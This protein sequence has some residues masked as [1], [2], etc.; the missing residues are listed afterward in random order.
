LKFTYAGQNVKDIVFHP[1][2]GIMLK[3]KP[4]DIWSETDPSHVRYTTDGT[5]PTENSAR[6]QQVT[7]LSVPSEFKAKLFSG[8]RK[9]AVTKTGS[10][11]EGKPLSPL[12]KPKNAV[13]GGFRYAYY[14]GM[15]N[16]LPDFSKL[17][18]IK[19]GLINKEFDVQK[20]ARQNNF[21]CLIEGHLEVQEDG[22][23]FF[24][25]ATGDASK[26]YLGNQLLI[27]CKSIDGAENFA[28]YIVPLE[29][30]FYPV[31]LEYLKKE[32][33][34]NLTLIYRPPNSRSPKPIPSDIQYSSKQIGR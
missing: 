29:K 25:L 32:A 31:R 14:E 11:K 5:Q 8:R 13:P 3:D 12:A 1:M 19:K 9:N 24:G 28:T 2:N 30:G 26:L 10:F 18:P 7:T 23:Y 22:Y 21:A 27:D 17:K 16:G 6:L 20:F 33:G 34:S 4:I 15:W